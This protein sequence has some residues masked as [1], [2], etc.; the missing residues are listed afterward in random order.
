MGNLRLTREEVGLRQLEI[1]SALTEPH[2]ITLLL[3]Q[4]VVEVA[5]YSGVESVAIALL[6][7][8]VIWVKHHISQF[9][10]NRLQVLK[11]QL[12]SRLHFFVLKDLFTFL[13][14]SLTHLHDFINVLILEFYNL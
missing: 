12:L 6:R 7:L 1:D 11:F 8:A 10:M 4:Q 13:H 5:L 14:N 9:L 3:H 2:N